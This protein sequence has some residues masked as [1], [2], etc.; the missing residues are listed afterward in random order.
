[1]GGLIVG[2]VIGAIFSA[3]IIGFGNMILGY[4]SDPNTYKT[5]VEKGIEYAPK[6]VE[7]LQ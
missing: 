5:I 2:I 4:L 7:A 1:M 3:G 6:A